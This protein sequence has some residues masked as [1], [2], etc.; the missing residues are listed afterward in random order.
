MYCLGASALFG[1]EYILASVLFFIGVVWITVKTALWEE[2]RA[3]EHKQIITTFV[4]SVGVF[5]YALSLWWI[6]CRVQSVSALPASLAHQ[7]TQ[8]PQ[9]PSPIRSYLSMNLV[10]DAADKVAIH[11][12]LVLE[13]KGPTEISVSNLIYK[14]KG[15]HLPDTLEPVR[16][17]IPNGRLVSNG[18]ELSSFLGDDL[19]ASAN[20]SIIGD[21]RPILVIYGFSIRAIDLHPGMILEPIS[22]QE[23]IGVV[24][25]P[26]LGLIDAMNSLPTGTIAFWFP[27]KNPDGSPNAPVISASPTRQIWFDPKLRKIFFTMEIGGRVYHRAASLPKKEYE[28]DFVMATWNTN[29]TVHI[30]INGRNQTEILP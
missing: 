30:F 10:I 28:S 12:H 14:T 23:I 8:Q 2:T 24:S 4:I 29:G 17:I 7:P 25:E 5:V 3:H 26:M 6:S 13:N 1:D 20:Y 16:K 19:F 11:F 15:V 21:E 9:Q 27:E 22:R 18:V